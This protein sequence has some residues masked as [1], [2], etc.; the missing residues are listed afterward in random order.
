MA[1]A[2]TTADD[3]ASPAPSWEVRTA[4]ATYV[5][6]DDENY[7]QPTVAADRGA[8][9]IEGRYNYEDRRTVSGFIGWNFEAG[10]KVKLSVTPMFGGMVGDTDGVVPALELSLEIGRVEFYSEGEYML[11]LE[12]RRRRYLYNWSEL[13]LWPTEWLRAGLVTQRTRVLNRPRDIQRGLLTGVTIGKCEGV[14]YLFN[15]GSSDHY[16]VASVSVQF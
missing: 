16:L 7:V 11:N 15:P 6:P 3:T 14:L 10:E 1:M 2:Q 9:H 4:L 8:L 5:V 13:S 12:H